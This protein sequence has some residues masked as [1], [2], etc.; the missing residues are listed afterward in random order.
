MSVPSTTRRA[1]LSDEGLLRVRILDPDLDIP[2]RAHAGDAGLDLRARQGVSLPPF[3]RAAV[4]TGIAVAI[5]SGHGG[6]VL[7]RS[8]LARHHGVTLANSPG[9]IDAGYRGEVIVVLLNLDPI[10]THV[11]HR[12]DRIAQLVVMP[13]L[14]SEPEWVDDLGDTERG[15][16]GFGSTGF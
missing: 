9:L 7:P 13:V 14:V 6:F 15:G 1:A 3:A 8:G 12:G 2:V 16:G 11:I 10:Q 4:P 5:P